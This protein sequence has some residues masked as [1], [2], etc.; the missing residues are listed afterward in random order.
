MG[1]GILGNG[2]YQRYFLTAG[3]INKSN[4]ILIMQKSTEK[5]VS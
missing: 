5:L 3:T 4:H 2:Y 1:L